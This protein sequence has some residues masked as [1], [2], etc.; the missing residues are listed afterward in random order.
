M[1][2]MVLLQ[3]VTIEFGKLALTLHVC[4]GG[5]MSTQA[6]SLISLCVYSFLCRAL[7]GLLLCYL[8]MSRLNGLDGFDTT[9][10]APTLAIFISV[11]LPDADNVQGIDDQVGLD[12]KIE[13]RVEGK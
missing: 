6:L 2:A 11:K 8:S 9:I 4:Q 7:I 5:T 1:V 3:G 13:G 10:C 12:V